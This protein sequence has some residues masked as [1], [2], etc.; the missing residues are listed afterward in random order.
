VFEDTVNPWSFTTH[1]LGW[2]GFFYVEKNMDGITINRSVE[3]PVALVRS[4]LIL[5]GYI[6][7]FLLI[8]IRYF[9]RKDILS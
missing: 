5:L 6:V 2:K 1:M 3:N 9:N 4:G 7:L 8:S